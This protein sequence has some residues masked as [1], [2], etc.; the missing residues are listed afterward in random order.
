MWV[1][2]MFEG[3]PLK[4]RILGILSEGEKWNYEIVKQM[5]DEYNMH[6][7]YERDCINFDIVEIASN[8]MVDV[9]DIKLDEEGFY[10]KDALL[11]KY[12]LNNRGKEEIEWLKGNMKKK[13]VK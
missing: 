7:D 8:G 5:Q 10:K 11:Q 4:F 6:S 9:T 12:S 2:K 3:A 1:I 13:E